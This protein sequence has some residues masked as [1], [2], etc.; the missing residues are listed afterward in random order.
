MIKLFCKN[1]PSNI[2]RQL[3]FEYKNL[4]KEL[5]FLLSTYKKKYNWIKDIDTI[6]LLLAM[7]IYYKRVIAPLESVSDFYLNLNKLNDVD[8]IVLGNDE[9]K[10]VAFIKIEDIVN[11]F[12]RILRIFGLSTK[13]FEYY[14]ISIFLDKIK[15]NI[16][17]IDEIYDET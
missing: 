6:K 3:Y 9:L 12:F 14:N 10:R 5:I 15:K 2:S 7:S 17:F 13:I 8:G 16:D 11:K 1:L 4:E